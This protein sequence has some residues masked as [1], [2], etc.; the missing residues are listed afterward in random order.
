MPIIRSRRS[1]TL[2][3]VVVATLIFSLAMA[4]LIGIFVAGTR[5]VLHF[6]ERMTGSEMGKL[7]IDPIQLYVRQDTW[8]AST[9]A[10]TLG[11]TYCNSSGSNQNPACP[12]VSTQRS[13]NGVSYDAQ[14]DVSS[15]SGMGARRVKTKVSWSEFSP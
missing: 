10:L 8:D 6:R 15:I 7:F 1:F 3:E 11:T 5:N 4:G 9:N 13:V 12:S 2:F 14:Y